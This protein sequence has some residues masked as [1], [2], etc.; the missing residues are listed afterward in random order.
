M[1][2]WTGVHDT[3]AS[4]LFFLQWVFPYLIGVGEDSSESFR[5]QGDKPCQSWRN[6]PWIFIGRTDAKADALILW[7]YDVKNQ[8]IGKKSDAEKD[9]RQE[10]GVTEDEMLGWRH[11]LDGHE[12]EQAPGDSEGQ[13]SL[14]CCSPWGHRVR[15]NLATEHHHCIWKC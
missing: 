11:R 1:G 5:Q 9:W 2:F 7:P 15:Y 6:Q 14:A 3:V 13:G 8:L 4:K 12:S 10:K